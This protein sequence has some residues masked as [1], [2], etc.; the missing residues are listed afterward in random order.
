MRLKIDAIVIFSLGIKSQFSPDK[1]ID[2]I[3]TGEQNS[4]IFF[5]FVKFPK[6]DVSVLIANK[7]SS[8]F[9][10]AQKTDGFQ[11]HDFY[12]RIALA[13]FRFR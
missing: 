9:G 8:L 3:F 4:S 6:N 5:G 11:E 7:L 12:V 13:F 2:D 10:R 1:N